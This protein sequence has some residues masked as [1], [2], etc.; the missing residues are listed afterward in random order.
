MLRVTALALACFSAI[1]VGWTPST[2]LRAP[3]STVRAR[4]CMVDQM[5][6][7]KAKG[8][9]ANVKD[10]PS[11]IEWARAAWA[12]AKDDAN[13]DE[14]C[15]L[16]DKGAPDASRDWYFC[17]EPSADAAMTCEAMPEWMGTLE[18]G[19]TVYICSTVK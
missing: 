2:G 11:N 16:I 6:W 3:A 10:A 17:S 9:V 5:R 12:A 13:L 18:S 19:E 15:Y 7:S 1:A 4:V 14:G 8:E